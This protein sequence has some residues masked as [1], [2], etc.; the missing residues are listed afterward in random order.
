MQHF[1]LAQQQNKTFT[2]WAGGNFKKGKGKGLDF[3]N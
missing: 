2:V 1:Q 3:N